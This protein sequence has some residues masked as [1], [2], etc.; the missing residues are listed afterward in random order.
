MAGHDPYIL[1]GIL[2][3][4]A[5][6]IQTYN[7]LIHLVRQSPNLNMFLPRI[8]QNLSQPVTSSP[9]NGPAMVLTVLST[10]FNIL[11]PDN[12]VRYHVFLAIISVVKSNGMYEALRPQLKNVDRWIAEWESDEAEQQKLFL[13]IAMVAEDAGETEY[14]LLYCHSE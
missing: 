13:E 5:E 8:C 12:D 7:L 1:H 10:I 9:Q 2:I 14:V 3:A 4:H 6:F 11:Q